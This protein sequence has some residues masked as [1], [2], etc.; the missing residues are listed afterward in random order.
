MLISELFAKLRIS[1]YLSEVK[2]FGVRSQD[3]ALIREC[4][5]W[6]SISY[7]NK[8]WWMCVSKSRL[9][10]SWAQ[11]SPRENQRPNHYIM[12]SRRPIVAKKI[13]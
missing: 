3:Y 11:V 10:R 9:V 6:N 5:K 8:K 4:E 7:N 13:V 1:H 2:D 12:I